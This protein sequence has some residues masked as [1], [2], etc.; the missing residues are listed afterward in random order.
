MPIPVGVALAALPKVR[1]LECSRREDQ[2]GDTRDGRDFIESPLLD[3]G[4]VPSSSW[5]EY[6][7][8]LRAIWGGDT[9]PFHVTDTC[10]DTAL[11]DYEFEA[12]SGIMISFSILL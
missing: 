12:V 4:P 5:K 2:G 10:P 1:C 8:L 9:C 7:G 11:S 3:K 6:V